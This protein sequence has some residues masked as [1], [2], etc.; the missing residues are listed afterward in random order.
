MRIIGI[1][2]S[3]TMDRGRPIVITKGH[4]REDV[5]GLFITLFEEVHAQNEELQA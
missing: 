5:P 4:V 3:E 2:L 1:S